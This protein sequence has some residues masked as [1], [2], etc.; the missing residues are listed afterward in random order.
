MNVTL[1]PGRKL[2]YVLILYAEIV[3]YRKD[4]INQLLGGEAACSQYCAVVYDWLHKGDNMQ[5][6]DQIAPDL[7]QKICGDFKPVH[8][9]YNKSVAI[10]GGI[11]TVL[12]AVLAAIVSKV[13]NFKGA[14]TSILILGV[15]LVLAGLTAYLSWEFLGSRFHCRTSRRSLSQNM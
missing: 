12:A 4:L 5:H 15:I 7:F 3:P 14:T 10:A 6:A 2:I 1:M 8:P 9:P 13:K 11:I